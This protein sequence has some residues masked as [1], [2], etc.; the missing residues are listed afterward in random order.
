MRIQNQ[1]PLM[2]LHGQNRDWCLQFPLNDLIL[3]F[4]CAGQVT[5]LINTLLLKRAT[6]FLFGTPSFLLVLAKFDQLRGGLS[7]ESDRM[8]LRVGIV[9]R[10]CSKDTRLSRCSKKCHWEL[11][12][13]AFCLMG[14]GN[15]LFLGEALKGFELVRWGSSC[16]VAFMP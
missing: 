6:Q 8:P 12:S 14:R 2:L 4:F 1:T 5:S 10:L 11:E 13:E 7:K 9:A 3:M 16:R 15:I